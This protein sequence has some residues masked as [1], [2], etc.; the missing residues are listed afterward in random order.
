[1]RRPAVE[2][3]DGDLV[4]LR[5]HRLEHLG[6][7]IRPRVL[8]HG[9]AIRRKLGADDREKLDRQTAQR[10]EHTVRGPA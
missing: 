2:V 3:D 1:M 10:I 7:E 8:E 6:R 9:E 4:R 5:L